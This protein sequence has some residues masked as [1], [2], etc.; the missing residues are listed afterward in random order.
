MK[1]VGSKKEVWNNRAEKTKN[2]LTKDCLQLNDKGNVVQKKIKACKPP[3]KQEGIEPKPRKPNQWLIH[4]KKFR[5]EN[6]SMPYKVAMQ[7]AKETYNKG[8][9]RG[10]VRDDTTEPPETLERKETKPQTATEGDLK[11]APK[12]KAPSRPKAEPKPTPKAEPKPKTKPT[13]NAEPKYKPKEP[14]KEDRIKAIVEE[15]DTPIITTLLY[16]MDKRTYDAI[17]GKIKEKLK[18]KQS[19]YVNLMMAFTKDYNDKVYEKYGFKGLMEGL[20]EIITDI[21]SETTDDDMPDD[22]IQNPILEGKTDKIPKGSLSRRTME[23][24]QKGIKKKTEE[25]RKATPEAEPKEYKMWAEVKDKSGLNAPFDEYFTRVR[26]IKFK[27]K[28]TPYGLE[29]IFKDIDD[30]ELA[31]DATLFYPRLKDDKIF[32]WSY[33]SYPW[34]TEPKSPPKEEPEEKKEKSD[35]GVYGLDETPEVKKLFSLFKDNYDIDWFVKWSDRKCNENYRKYGACDLTAMEILPM[36]YLNIKD[37]K[38]D[39]ENVVE[40]D[41]LYPALVLM[42][43][44]LLSKTK[45]NYTPFNSLYYYS[46]D[47]RN[48]PKDILDDISSQYNLKARDLSK[49]SQMSPSEQK[50]LIEKYHAEPMQ[51][52]QNKDKYIKN[53]MYEKHGVPHISENKQVVI[54]E[55]TIKHIESL[56]VPEKYKE[57]YEKLKM[58]NKVSNEPLYIKAKGGETQPKPEPKVEPKEKKE[59]YAFETDGVYFIKTETDTYYYKVNYV[60]LKYGKNNKYEGKIIGIVPVRINK[61]DPIDNFESYAGLEASGDIWEQYI[62]ID[63]GLKYDILKKLEAKNEY[64]GK[65]EEPTHKPSPK[66]QSKTKEAPK[67]EEKKGGKPS[68]EEPEEKS[69]GVLTSDE[70]EFRQKKMKQLD[71]KI[72]ELDA[73]NSFYT[74]QRKKLKSKTKL[75]KKEY[76][77]AFRKLTG[78]GMRNISSAKI[79]DIKEFIF[80]QKKPNGDPITDKDLIDALFMK[81]ADSLDDSIKQNIESIKTM[82]ERLQNYKNLTAK[83]IQ[84]IKEG[85]EALQNLRSIK[86]K[87]KTYAREELGQLVGK[88]ISRFGVYTDSDLKIATGRGLNIQH[89]ALDRHMQVLQGRHEQHTNSGQYYAM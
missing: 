68:E 66:E 58:Y 69:D 37:L 71:E 72:I 45:H 31:L 60:K 32:K 9:V 3:K 70:E 49:W 89:V 1:A 40:M 34:H 53:P 83:G 14:S 4:L 51:V 76:I 11:P 80:K 78:T 67:P 85:Y 33:S 18:K 46:G 57:Q 39:N 59:I 47:F 17:Q 62:I 75:N 86:P 15:W 24:I 82:E 27:Q 5:S 88:P 64:T 54:N 77:E 19:V 65:I 30:L 13:P 7:K 26:D 23:K 81:T 87:S 84:E 63:E 42:T 36:V 10:S 25:A 50:K 2:G 8:G 79:G 38:L 43:N 61:K 20:V 16:Q 29:F 48:L 73:D 28:K 74:I 56:G 41:E 6:P 44:Y 22:F 12:R 35:S 52:I 55:K 21:Y